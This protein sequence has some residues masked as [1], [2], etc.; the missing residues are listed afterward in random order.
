MKINLSNSELLDTDIVNTWSNNAFSNFEGEICRKPLI[1]E[2]FINKKNWE[3]YRACL[4]RQE[5]K[6]RAEAIAL[7]KEREFELEKLKTQSQQSALESLLRDSSSEQSKFPTGLVIGLSV[8][9]LGAI[10]FIIYKT[11]KK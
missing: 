2:T 7:E 8:V 9:A 5:G 6:A 10:G 4:K 1:R 3:E 11:I